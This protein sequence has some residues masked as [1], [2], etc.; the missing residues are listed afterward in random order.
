M[1]GIFWY[2]LNNNEED[3]LNNFMK[4]KH[5]GPDNTSH[6]I[7][8]NNF[9]GT[10]RLAIINNSSSGNQ[11]LI[12]DD[13]YL[14]CNGQ[15]YN[16]LD[17][18]NNDQL[19]T[20]V[21][22][23]LNLFCN[24]VYDSID[25]LV[26]NLDGDFSFVMVKNNDIYIARDPIGVRPLFYGIDKNGK[27]ICASSEVK[28]IKDLNDVESCHVF[29]PGH[30]YD[31]ISKKIRSYTDIYINP[32]NNILLTYNE[33]LDII[34]LKLR[35]AIYKRITNSDRPIAFLCSGGIDSSIILSI[36]YDILDSLGKTDLMHMF[37]MSYN[38]ENSRSDDSFYA[39][40][41]AR[42]YNIKHT[43][44]SFTWEDVINN[45]KNI[46]LHI[47]TYDP[48]TIRASVP[49]Y[50]LAKYIKENTDYKVIL[51]GE[52]ADELFMGYNIFMKASD[53]ELAN[54]ETKRL[55]RNIHMFDALRADR[56][57]NAHGLEI[58]VPFLDI[59]FC[60]SIFQINGIYKLYSNGIEKKLLRDAFSDIV[61]LSNS[62]IL[63]RAKERFSDGCGFS[64]VPDLLRY[65]TPEDVPNSGILSTKEKYEKETYKKWFD[66]NY[67]NLEH[68]I[69]KRDN[70]SWCNNLSV[71]DK[72]LSI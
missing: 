70:P 55:I 44:V 18:E 28:A 30:V 33:C 19:R 51:S 60:R 57:F 64:Y 39:T 29:P 12:K 72:L 63:D 16:Y 21:D 41:L 9:L 40:L 20:D 13:T 35:K 71:N 67:N 4:L 54:E 23:I 17:F 68:L 14:I 62:R 3:A 59:D 7:I 43:R 10:H 34:R 26:Y 38:K 61:Q 47:E 48:N 2:I 58:R 11:P 36:A 53:P 46:A 32:N 37:S 69:I 66:E 65:W 50:F 49:M 25:N 31:S 1:C 27:I 6:I 5:R 15:I 52:G 24:K 45:I 8:N 42:E 56:C 22:I